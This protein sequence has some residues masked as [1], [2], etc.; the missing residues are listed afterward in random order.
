MSKMS[1][2]DSKALE[3][4]K[5]FFR[6]NKGGTSNFRPR[7][8]FELTPETEKELCGE[9]SLSHRVKAIKDLSETVLNH[10]L[11]DMA[12]EKLWHCL[13]DLLQDSVAKEHR[14][15]AFSFFRC[16][17]QGQ[18]ERLG[19]MRVHFFRLVKSHEN[20]EDTVPR[21]ELL[22]SLTD[23]GKDI[24]YIE[25]EIGPF[26][27]EWMPEITQA[28]RELDFLNMIVNVIKYNAAYIDQ[29]IVSGLVQNICL[30]CC[31]SPVQ[32][33]VLACLQVLDTIVCYSN[34][35]PDSLATFI[36]ALCR[37]VNMEVYCP[38]SWKIMRNLLGTHLGHSSLY[39]MCQFLQDPSSASDVGLLR[40]AVFYINMALWGDKRVATLKCTHTSV[41][42][43]FNM[44]LQCRH[45]L[46]MYEVMLSIQ[47]LV[48]K[49]GL[50]LQDPAWDLV[51]AI[52]D[53]I[54]E[55]IERSSPGTPTALVGS[56]LHETLCTIEQLIELG[57]FNGSVRRVFQIIERCA[58]VRPE[59]SVLRL[60]SYLS[61]SI[62]PTRHMWLSKLNS[63]MEKY[64]RQETR[65]NIRIKVLDILSSVIKTNR[66]L[67]EDDI[68]ER[69]VLPHLDHVYQENDL[70][71][72][73][74]AAQLLVDLCLDCETKRCLDLM[75]IL[76]KLMMRTFDHH[77]PSHPG[78]TEAEAADVKTVV[79]GVIKMFT[80][81][82]YVLPSVHAVKAY[83]ML[84]T[85][86]ERHYAKPIV[87][88]QV[89]IIRHNILECFLRLRVDSSFRLGYP[90]Q[91]AGMRY[92]P[93][94][95]VEHRCAPPSPPPPTSPA[96]GAYP[97]AEVT[98]ISL[99]LACR[100]VVTCLIQELDWRVLL[101]VLQEIVQVMKN[102]ALILSRQDNDIDSLATALC[103]MVSDKSL[104]LPDT[105]RNTPTKFTRSDFH[106]FV[107]P[108]LASLA[109]YHSQLEPSLQQRLIKCLEFGL[110]S[111][112]ARQC[113]MALTICTLEM[114][115]AM[116][117]LLPE[118]LLNLSKIS[119]TVHIAIPIL[120]FL[121]TLTRLPKVYANFVGDQ[122]MSVFAITLPYTNPFK[123]NHYT[124]S[125]AH[126]VMAVW[127]LKCRLPF[128]RDFVKFITTGLKANVLVPFEEGQVI[129]PE[130]INEDS[131]NRKRSSSLTEQ[132]SR[133]RER[134][135][136]GTGRLDTRAPVTDLKPPIDD[137]LMAFHRELTETCI[138][139]MARYTFSTCSAVPKR[140]PTADFL[141]SGGQSMTWLLGNKLITVTTSGCS[142]KALKNG[143]CD[144]C[145]QICRLDKEPLL[146]PSVESIEPESKSRSI[147]HKTPLTRSVSN[148]ITPLTLASNTSTAA[149]SPSDEG[150]RGLEASLHDADPAR[151]DQL[152]Y[153]GERQERQL[154][155]CWCQGW[156]EIYVRRPTGDMSWAMRLQ[157]EPQVVQSA[158]QPP[159][160]DIAT[161]FLPSLTSRKLPQDPFVDFEFDSRG[162]SG[163]PE[164]LTS[165]PVS[166][167][168][169]PIRRSPSR[170]SS[171]DSVDT[172]ENDE[173]DYDDGISGRSRNPVRRSNS[174]P[175]MSASWKNPFM[176]QTGGTG[177]DTSSR[178]CEA[179]SVTTSNTE[180]KKKQ[181]YTKD[182]RVN[183]EAIPEEMGTTPPTADTTIP[184]Q[185]TL[186]LAPAQVDHRKMS[187]PAV[188]QDWHSVQADKSSSED[189]RQDLE[190]RLDP[191]ALPPL[192]FKRD[193]GHTISVMS[194]VRKPRPDWDVLKSKSPR[195]KE[196]PRSGVSPS[197][198]FLQLY[199]SAHFGSV[200]EKP[201]ALP[202]SQMV[203]RAVKNL[204]RIP[205]YETHKVGVIYVGP[206]QVNSETDILRNQFGSLRYAEFLQRLGT[207][208]KLADADPQNVFLGGLERNGNDGKFA[209]I[210]Q[211]DVMQVTFHVAT[212]MP[213]R[214]NDPNCNAKKLHI[215]NDY[216][217]IVYNESGEQYNIRT[218]KCQYNYACVMVEPL[219]H[220]IN[221]VMVK[222]KEELVEHIGH[223]EPKIVSDQNVALLARQLALHAN[224][225]SMVACSLKTEGQDPYT[226]NWLERLRQI[227]RVRAKVLH[228]LAAETSSDATKYSA[229]RMHMDDFTEYT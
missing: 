201:L 66:R 220:G 20:P 193:R 28:G 174:S 4:L 3:K 44:A 51:L 63:L 24:V 135:I 39:T 38:T 115:D 200:P 106:G 222:A 46:V 168:C 95:I 169:S 212:L 19:M 164:R 67:Y 185:H 219:E 137:A 116:V 76:E 58:P 16:L 224:L 17:V 35:P 148:E 77:E 189:V 91:N 124:V 37:T 7:E 146:S 129:K 210:W 175:E 103:S 47:R 163:L 150:R 145:W 109:S 170:H 186:L 18:Y 144:K 111:R 102:K 89:T 197:F 60:V 178:S 154:C 184:A 86:I 5:Q 133:R 112:S 43:S 162:V 213:T 55:H 120:E 81:Y 101:L 42:P 50:Q 130:I 64:Y 153:G 142:Q 156:A 36:G 104:C 69:I 123:Y 218:V 65:T 176:N 192:S 110:A 161:L 147:T 202:N 88:E 85:Y 31:N 171:R 90:Q 188:I 52:I 61:G 59:A 139:L 117:K 136:S 180:S 221:Q 141:L 15:L 27:L 68:V 62:V 25:E 70:A 158:S 228:E 160:N 105:L 78:L 187:A 114:R 48:N 108:V 194:P 92:S 134:P 98:Y 113:V 128:R 87:F 209:Y 182:L 191:S 84:V 215:G 131:S 33:V 127:F 179:P 125:L 165:D 167:P 97:A 79:T 181:T 54:I 190:G 1:S 57:Q 32:Q 100:A 49:Y 138:D 30:L 157:N 216:V 199:H 121:S 203:H 227:K 9:A 29:E 94:L 75:D 166:I 8:E 71:V 173:H 149:S 93:Y 172:L 11:E 21:L 41:L 12:V 122:Y 126:H 159:M 152:V 26:L 56:H 2:K 119:A 82:I 74:S 198:V 10:R 107:F 99:T 80:S 118:V 53:T 183:C 155:A 229:R 214:E 22:I 83:K 204:D 72:R 223:S 195:A 132:G 45:H 14:H 205:P 6:I 206:G 217:T 207:L 23:N 151:L 211:D 225:A 13:Q 34:L 143:L 140:Q 208:I 177:E 96:P 73:N 226:S 196:A 40:G